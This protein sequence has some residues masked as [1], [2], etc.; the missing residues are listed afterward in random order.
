MK[1]F[2][3]LIPILL[4]TAC[5]TLPARAANTLITATITITNTAG[6]T[7]G[8][9]I[10]VNSSVKTWTNSVVIPASQILT[11]STIYGCATNL[12]NAIS[13]GPFLNLSVGQLTNGVSLQ[14]LTV[15]GPMVVTL[16][17][18]WGT[19]VLTTNILTSAQVVRVPLTVEY[20]SNQTAIATYLA[21]GLES[22]TYGISGGAPVLSNVVALTNV[23][24]I[25]GKK[26]IISPV[27][28]NATEIKSFYGSP[29]TTNLI[30]YGLAASSPGTNF[31]SEQFGIGAVASGDGS[32]AFGASA[33]AAGVSSSAFGAS[34]DATAD[35]STALGTSALASGLSS[36]AIGVSSRAQGDNST[37]IGISS[38]AVGS[39]SVA[40][41]NS[42]STANAANSTALGQGSAANYPNSTAIGQGVSTTTSNQVVVGQS[43][44]S[45]LIPGGLSAGTISN[46]VFAATNTFPAGSDIAFGRYAITSI[47]NGNNAAVVVGTNVFIQLSGPSGAFSINGI[48]GGRDGKFLIVINRTGQAMTLANDSGVDPTAANRLYS[49]S[50]ADETLSGN[51]SAVLI[52]NSSLSRWIILSFMNGSS[53]TYTGGYGINLSGGSIVWNPPA[54]LTNTVLGAN[55]SGTV[56]A[57]STATTAAGLIGSATGTSLNLSGGLIAVGVESTQNNRAAV[58]SISPGASPYNWTNTFG[59]NVFVWVQSGT[60]SDIKINGSSVF[61]STGQIIPMQPTEWITV[62]YSGGPPGMFYKAF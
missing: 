1:R 29:T 17:A 18:G 25:T 22:S 54:P 3:A 27:L 42:A 49:N 24:T 19:V 39:S 36:I 33:W 5:G 20:A 6:T 41:G 14:T 38:T 45:V 53:G 2:L 37:A 57:A 23:Q 7:N 56:N 43:S 30:N 26:T 31:H 52:Y 28:T 46:A 58:T 60:V 9:T 50:G 12:F 48:A 34:A 8:Q 15:N 61:G 51:S 44:Q 35:N 47:A 55:V 16:S 11:N 21:Q 40:I 32:A 13:V 10:T 4:L 59:Y 62:T